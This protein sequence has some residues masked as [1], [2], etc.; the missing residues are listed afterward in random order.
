M[1]GATVSVNLDIDLV[2]RWLAILHGDAPGLTHIASTD[3]WAGR[4]FPDLDQAAAYVADLDAQG[5]QGIYARVTTLKAPLEPGKRGGAADTMA[6]PALWADLDLA[7]PGHA[8]TNLPPDEEAGRKVIATSGLPDPTIWVHSGGGLYPIWLL[9]TPH[10]VDDDLDDVKDLAAG[11]QRAVE[12]A[13]AQLGWH[14]GRGVGDLARVLRIPGTTNRKEGLAR[15]CRIIDATAKRYTIGELYE[16]L[17][18]ALAAIP[19]PDTK[20]STS[21]GHTRDGASPG[22][23]YAARIDWADILE[24]HGWTLSH[25][26]GEIRYWTRPG[27]RHGIS[28]T[29]N[30]L[31]TDRLH[32]FSTSTVFDANESYSKF[33]A[34]AVL[35][36]HGDHGAAAKSLS[37]QG[38]GE[39]HD[40]AAEQREAFRDLLGDQVDTPPPPADPAAG[41]RAELDVTNPAVAAGWLRDEVGRGRLSGMFYRGG[42]IVHTPREGEAGYV[43]PAD[44]TDDDGPA[45]I[46]I[47]SDSTLASRIQYRYGCFRWV[48]RGEDYEAVPA[49]FPRAAARVAVD[50][51]EELP[52]LRPLAGVVHSPVL[53][54]DGTVLDR[55]GYDPATRLLYL[56]DPGLTVPPV[57]EHPTAEQVAAAVALLDEMTAGFNFLTAHDKVNYYGLL[58][59]PLLRALAPPPYKLGAIG[60]PQPGSGKTLL[61][62]VLRTVHGGVF[63]AEMPEDDAELRKQVTTILDVTTGPVVHFDNVSGVLRSSTLA[64]LLTST[65][66][67]DRRLGANEMVNAQ[68]DRLWVVTGNNLT[69]GGDLAR[70]TV[71]VTIDPGVPHP[72]LRTDFAIKDLEGWARTHRGQLLAALL[73]LVRAWVAAGGPVGA[74]RGSDGYARWVEIVSGVFSY[75]G[76]PGRFADPESARQSVGEDDDEWRDFLSKVHDVFGAQVWTVKELLGQVDTG[77]LI[78]AKPITLDALPAALA[79]K[80]AHSPAGVLAVSRSLGKWLAN[81]D[82]RW[83]GRLCARSAGQDD[84]TKVKLWRV[85]NV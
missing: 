11:W 38:Y 53:R 22:D 79:E 6:L 83:A 73:T 64:G 18:A 27:K 66:W 44:D 28:A 63:R 5:R 59:T 48:K 26:Q 7:G 43:P 50:V 60:A 12:A 58:L 78:D 51:P 54:A 47:V 75:A 31:G 20:T 68:N 46:R 19:Q 45:Q 62:T 8:E 77:N 3:D 70:R 61:A 29:T 33:G 67:D 72:E 24:P 84:H 13:A 25:R 39:Q 32:V 4:A 2:R 52:N 69:L 17:A 37:G 81:R 35:E 23:D 82:G 74:A 55:P 42:H 9:D 14:Y 34:Y 76:V 57:P 49:M 16:A 15:P 80:A 40:P 85:E 65:V 56:P 41:W 10:V 36:H 1:N 21:T 30:A 71:W